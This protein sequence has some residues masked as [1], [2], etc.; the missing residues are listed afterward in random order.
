VAL[1]VLGTGLVAGQTVKADARSVNGE[2]PRHVKLKNEIENLLDQV[3][4]LYTKHNSNYQQY[5]AQ[6]GRLDLRQKA[7]YLKGLNDWAERLL[8]ELNGEDVKKVLGKVA[9]EKDDLEKEVKQLK[10]KIDKKEK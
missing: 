7:E 3:T 2:F 6:A 8:Q 4:Q 9:F 5:N 10:E 1:T